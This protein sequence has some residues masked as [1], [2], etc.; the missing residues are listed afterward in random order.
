MED[1]LRDIRLGA[2]A[3]IRDKGFAATV[4][5][6]LAVGIA[7]NTA[8]F[9]IVHSVLL[10]PL[11]V[12]GADQIVLMANQYPKAGVPDSDNSSAG[13]YYDRLREV[14]ALSQQALFRSTSQTVEIGGIPQQVQGM[15]V[16]PSFFP[17]IGIMP[18]Y[19]RAFTP[20]EGEVGREQKVILSDSLW[21]SLYGAD[22]SAIGR[23]LR[24][25]GRPYV[26]VG[27]MPAGFTFTDPKVR[28]WIP[29]AF[30]ASQKTTYHSNNW[31]HIGRLKPGATIQRVQ[32]QIAA[33]N[34][35]NMDRFPALKP[36]L[37]NAGYF[38][39]VESFEHTIVKDVEPVLYLLWGGAA[40]VLL[41]GALNLA[42]IALARL[43]ARSKDLAM[44]IALGGGGLQLL[45]Q[46]LV[47]NLMISMAGGTAGILLGEG[48]LRGLV[49]L[50]FDRFPRA[51][52]VRIDGVVILVALGLAA[53]VGVAI[54][55]LP[56][57][58]LMKLD[59]NRVLHDDSRTGT[60][61]VAT[62]RTRQ[63]L[64][65]AQIA[66]A[67]VLLTGAGLLLIS[68]RNLL[69]VDPGFST[70]RVLIASTSAP[71]IRYKD[72][73]A[74]RALMNRSLASLRTLPGVESAGA[75]TTVPFSGNYSDSVILAEGYQMRPGESVISP[76]QLTVTPGY[77]E[78][79]KIALVRGRYF[80]AADTESSKR[81]IIID[82][83]LANR[84]W[85][86][87]D[88][89]GRRMYQPQSAN[90]I[91]KTDANTRWLEVVGVVRS[92]RM[93]NLAGTGNRV[94]A[95][96]F[97][98]AQNPF[99]GFSF[100]IKTS[101]ESSAL[102]PALRAQIAKIDP[103]LALFG[104]RT[105]GE[106]SDLS[107]SS[108]RLTLILALGFAGVAVF[109]SVVGIYGVLAYLVTERR[110]EIGIRIALGATR[111]RVVTLV[112]REGLLLAGL[113]LVL[114]A[115]G[116]AALQKAV[117]SQ[118]YGVRPLDPAVMGGVI[119][120]LAAAT[121]AASLVPAR[122][123]LEVDPVAILGER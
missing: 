120:L 37:I 97:P 122:R 106:Q 27:I 12:P 75:T 50:H 117:A 18:E 109:L 25:G 22:R 3:L 35:A 112:L 40:F 23:E 14:T 39:S 29:L 102:E 103:E 28:L 34:A 36:L 107:L 113:G 11:P 105:M 87:R 81:V 9:A 119:L 82:E 20:D 45:R 98:Y 17:L 31:H 48:L 110:R 69:H 66:L 86:N 93:E 10:R 73:N 76:R 65:G 52:E 116:A 67:F 79:M 111:S 100:A 61:G 62:R 104:V 21:K 53:L 58:R 60:G 123:A 4:L 118:I 83:N 63:V 68:F 13:D 77:L 26:I 54:A 8:T 38:T 80:T 44:R 56:L 42:N 74:L 70:D 15:A 91:L 47:E 114:G 72:D 85:P 24:M 16:T 46:S 96:Y 57:G 49:F 121:V 1:L 90:D 115:A 43:T 108:R 55:C 32:A 19:G 95:Y 94:G 92:V 84:F 6:T 89:I 88:P 64:A 2:R 5:A 59:V 78:T 51:S 101:M 33:L 41:I 71:R 99:N 30:T 7:A